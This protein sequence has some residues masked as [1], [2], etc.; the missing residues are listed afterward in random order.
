M[1]LANAGALRGVLLCGA[2]FGLPA[3]GCQPG[4]PDAGGGSAEETPPPSLPPARLVV[5]GKVVPQDYEDRVELAAT[6]DTV[7]DATLSAQTAGTVREIARR[8]TIVEKGRPVARLDPS[9]A[10]A[11]VAQ[12]KAVVQAARSG[13]ELAEDVLK[14]Q[15]PLFEK[16]IISALE[17]RDLQSR[18]NQARANVA[19]SEAA[20][21]Q[22]REQLSYTRIDAPFT[23]RVESWAVE[24]GE[25][26]APGVPVVRLVD[27]ATV[28]V[29]AGVPERYARDIREGASLRVRFDTY[30]MPYRDGTAAFVGHAIDPRN[31]TFEVEVELDNADGALKPGMA[32]RLLLTRARHPGALVLPQTAIVRD[33]SGASI[34]VVDRSGERAVARRRPVTTES[35]ARGSVRIVSGLRPGDEVVLKGQDVLSDG[36]AVQVAAPVGATAEGQPE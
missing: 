25:Q 2:L 6:V 10:E 17:F 23:G 31:R 27:N 34:F 36:D 13:L 32:A 28:R 12:A 33:V 5:T 16:E 24:V 20:L 29:K 22:A 15:T 4:E 1:R 9:M 14:R 8:G 21:R 11:G 18:V 3:A 26:V 30:G 35:S 7:R 19:Q